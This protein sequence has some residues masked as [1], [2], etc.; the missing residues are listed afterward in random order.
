VAGLALLRAPQLA[1]AFA[2]QPG[3]EV[4]PWLDQPAP[5]PVPDVLGQPLR[6]EDL[7][8]WLTPNDQF[9]T[10]AHYEKPLLDATTWRLQ[11]GGLVQQPMVLTLD[12]LKARQRQEVNFTLE[13]SGNTGLP[14]LW[15]GIGNA[16]WAG[17]PLAPL[18][19]E[20]GILKNGIE[21]VF[22]GSD[23]GVEEVRDIKMSQHF[24]RS[25]SVP[26]AMDPHNLLC[27]EMNSEP[28]PQFHGF[29]VRLIAPGWYGIAN[30]KWLQRIEVLP[31]RYENRFMARDYVTIREQQID[32]QSV[33]TETSV[34]RAS[35]KSAPAK[36][37]RAGGQYR[38]VGTAWGAP[39]AQVEVQID[40]GTWQPATIDEG[41][42]AEFAWKLWSMAWPNPLPSEHTVTSRAID[43]EGHFQPAPDDPWI[44]GKHTYWESNAQITRRVLIAV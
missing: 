41:Q 20:A 13:C 21:V 1:E 23:M 9:F 7:N 25:M 38:I 26:D 14:F 16:T 36:V 22:F 11:I 44:A 30:V 40:G 27:Y 5:N 17:T 32:G 24:A 2:A 37:T 8:S 31:T 12:D 42:D 39:I 28:L 6:W 19:Q 10:I 15:G 18:L 29:P 35:L 3:E 33:W 34:G 4:I 43:T